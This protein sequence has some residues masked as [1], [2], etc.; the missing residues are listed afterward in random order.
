MSK[1]VNRNVETEEQRKAA[2]KLI[3]SRTLPFTLTV[4]EGKRRTNAQNRLQM[5]WMNEISQQLGDRTPEEARAYAKLTIA[6]PILR[7]G[8]EAFRESYDR[9]VRPL[10]YEQ[11]LAIMQEPL[12]LPVTRLMTT[13]QLTEYLDRI[14]RHFAEQGVILSVPDDLKFALA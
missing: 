12:D 11:K 4:T 9:V 7:A 3:E 1:P 6:V 13:K 5:L 10:A 8:N 14:Q 2:I